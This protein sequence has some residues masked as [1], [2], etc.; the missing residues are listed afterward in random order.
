MGLGRHRTARH[1]ALSARAQREAS[2]AVSPR[3]DRPPKGAA[4]QLP[5]RAG[6]ARE[7]PA[8]WVTRRQAAELGGVHYNT[9]LKWEREKLFPTKQRGRTV[10]ISEPRF[11]AVLEM[12]KAAPKGRP[13]GSK[14]RP[15]SVSDAA[16]APEPSGAVRLTGPSIDALQLLAHV[17]ALANGLAD[18]LESL[19]RLVR[20][21]KRGGRPPNRG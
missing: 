20:P 12:K 15:R 5:A 3:R 13:V 11:R 4:A 10:L 19:A 6:V 17:D 1:G 18:G 21:R 8:G 9:V 7:A 14:T 16:S 2:S